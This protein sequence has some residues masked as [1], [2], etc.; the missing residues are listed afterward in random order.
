[1]TRVS[2]LVDPGSAVAIRLA[3]A[4]VLPG[5]EVRLLQRRPVY[6]IRLGFAELALDRE[7][8]AHIR[9]RREDVEA[10]V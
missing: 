9:V 10:R 7:T 4:G 2:C 6:V 5:T 3:S 1:V 8:A